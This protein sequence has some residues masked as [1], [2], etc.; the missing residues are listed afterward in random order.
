MR[1]DIQAMQIMVDSMVNVPKFS[2]PAKKNAPRPKTEFASIQLIEQYVVGLPHR[3]FIEDI[4]DEF[5]NVA[6]HVYE[7]NSAAR[8]RFRITVVNGLGVASTQI[9]NGWTTETIKDLMKSTGYGYIKC[10]PISQE[11]AQLEKNW[12]DREG[13]SV[14]L[15]VTRTHRETLGRLGQVISITG[16]IY[17]GVDEALI[18]VDVPQGIL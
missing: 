10:N 9:A 6:Q 12:E 3:R 13:F 1:Q 17:E 16:L 7:Y 14:E 15:Y 5:G 4:L 8:L 18:N 11:D 2:Y